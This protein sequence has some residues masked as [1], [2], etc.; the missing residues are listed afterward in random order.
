MISNHPLAIVIVKKMMIE[1]NKYLNNIDNVE[2]FQKLSSFFQLYLNR[3]P[4][5][6]ESKQYLS[7]ISISLSSIC[8]PYKIKAMYINDYFSFFRGRGWT[9]ML[10]VKNKMLQQIPSL[11]SKISALFIYP[12]PRL[13][14]HN[15][16]SSGSFF[17]A[18][19]FPCN[20]VQ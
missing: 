19:K 13:N 12:H 1:M 14:T 16:K 20:D 15:L 2:H 8:F 9:L 5:R 11:P 7:E 3:F 10:K 4:R 18:Y 17:S 6:T